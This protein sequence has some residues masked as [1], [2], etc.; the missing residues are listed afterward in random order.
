MCE[1][2]RIVWRHE[3]GKRAVSFNGYVYRP[4]L[5]VAKWEGCNLYIES[6]FPYRTL[7]GAK[8]AAERDDCW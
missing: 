6:S 8:A 4:A 7:E 3:D 2:T 1:E 5:Y